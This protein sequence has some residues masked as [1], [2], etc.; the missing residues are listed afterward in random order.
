MDSFQKYL[1]SY[2]LSDY[3]SEISALLENDQIISRFYCELV[4]DKMSPEMFWAR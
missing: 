4:P 1:E 2:A 3:S